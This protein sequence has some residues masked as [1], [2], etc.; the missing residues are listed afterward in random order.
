MPAPR[1]GG[2]SPIPRP[3]DPFASPESANASGPSPRSTAPSAVPYPS[4]V[5]RSGDL[6]EGIRFLG[7]SGDFARFASPSPPQEGAIAW[8]CARYISL[9]RLRSRD[10]SRDRHPQAGHDACSIF[11]LWCHL[12]FPPAASGSTDGTNV[13]GRCRRPMMQARCS[14]A[15]KPPDRAC[16][17]TVAAIASS[18]GRSWR[19]S[20][21]SLAP[22]KAEVG[23]SPP[24][25]LRA[26]EG[27]AAG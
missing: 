8:R 11:E 23:V 9:F 22:L 17:S 3:R 18:P 7:H 25:G 24:P 5:R 2:E 16:G 26:S 21:K 4:D 10:A 27:R 6:T 15:S 14:L 19:D 12:A 13:E 20:E 1:P